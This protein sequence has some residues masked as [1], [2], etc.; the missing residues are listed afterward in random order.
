MLTIDTSDPLTRSRLNLQK[1]RSRHKRY[2]FYPN[3]TVRQSIEGLRRD[4]PTLSTSD[5]INDLIE[6][7]L[8]A[9]FPVSKQ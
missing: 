7:G 3:P 6:A 4:Y 2:D 5:V 8:K 1:F 9:L